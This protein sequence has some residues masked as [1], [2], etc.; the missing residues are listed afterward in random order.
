MKSRNF[1]TLAND[2]NT[3]SLPAKQDTLIKLCNLLAQ[4]ECIRNKLF[5]EADT[6][7]PSFI[8]YVHTP[9]NIDIDAVR[10]LSLFLADHREEKVEQGIYNP[11]TRIANIFKTIPNF[12]HRSA[13]V[14]SLHD[15]FWFQSA[16]EAGIIFLSIYNPDPIDV[17]LLPDPKA[18]ATRA[19]YS[20]LP[21][22]Q[23]KLQYLIDTLGILHTVTES[24]EKE[25]QIKLN[26]SV[27]A[28][29]IRE[30]RDFP[31]IKKMIKT[32]F[33]LHSYVKS[34]LKFRFLQASEI[35]QV[36]AAAALC[37]GTINSDVVNACK[38]QS[39]HME[40]VVDLLFS[41]EHDEKKLFSAVLHNEEYIPIAQFESKLYEYV[42]NILTIC[43]KA[44][45]YCYKEIRLPDFTVWPHQLTYQ[46][47]RCSDAIQS[48]INIVSQIG[49]RKEE[50][51][52]GA[53]GPCTTIRNLTWLGAS[54]SIQE[55]KEK[56]TSLATDASGAG[57]LFLNT[58]HSKCIHMKEIDMK[59]IAP[60]WLGGKKDP[61]DITWWDT[62][63]RE[64]NEETYFLAKGF[65][66]KSELE[67]SILQ[68]A[69]SQ[70]QRIFVAETRNKELYGDKPPY[71]LLII[72]I[73]NTVLEK[74]LH[75][76]VSEYSVTK[77]PFDLPDFY[78]EQGCFQSMHIND[79]PPNLTIVLNPLLP[80]IHAYSKYSSKKSIQTK[81]VFHSVIKKNTRYSQIPTLFGGMA[82]SSI[83]PLLLDQT[84]PIGLIDAPSE[85]HAEAMAQGTSIG[86]ITA[87]GQ[88][89][90]T[91]GYPSVWYEQIAENDIYIPL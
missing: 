40:H 66:N 58:D 35:L 29:S 50:L 69:F 26:E 36:A 75:E 18:E 4:Y 38:N 84:V 67:N 74:R 56:I 61:D 45:T 77:L 64:C 28:Q 5:T 21:Q 15:V 30:L 65:E 60:R 62:A 12:L 52:G 37:E 53:A 54:S 33:L 23:T 41:T 51:L 22:I 46:A 25:K 17:D 79:L 32:H 24:I 10:E 55:C 19:I 47:T 57:I 43:D 90:L 72:N 14:S 11:K 85:L 63:I 87:D 73:T 16:D 44:V 70:P 49:T 81:S 71:I 78:K 7:D 13:Q 83:V 68:L 42:H 76:F 88:R 2:L 86:Y 82:L 91:G 1:I 9:M 20:F 59:T 27:A 48:F 3:L 6:L 80:R 89:H 31:F 39:M 8:L 34:E